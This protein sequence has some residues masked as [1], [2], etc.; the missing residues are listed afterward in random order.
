MTPKAQTKLEALIDRQQKIMNQIKQ[1]Q[2]R[3]AA[4][5]R[6]LDTRRKILLGSIFE[7]LIIAQEFEAS[8]VNEWLKEYLIRDR[9]RELFKGY[10][11]GLKIE[12]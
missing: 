12:K 11:D 10:L 2:S 1:I 6:K 3:D 8:D 4:N 7:R 5:K 9:D